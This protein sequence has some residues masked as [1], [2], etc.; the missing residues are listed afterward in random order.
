MF[1]R[2]LAHSVVVK[3]L[4]FMPLLKS[5]ANVPKCKTCFNLTFKCVATYYYMLPLV[6]S[7]NFLNYCYK[8]KC[9]RTVFIHCL[10]FK[11][12]NINACSR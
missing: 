8:L 9:V 7:T 12:L 3:I 11:Y 1:E 6:T 2:S 10:V 5:F 4:N